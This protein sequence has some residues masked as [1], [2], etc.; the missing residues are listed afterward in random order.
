MTQDLLL[1]RRKPQ[2]GQIEHHRAE[3]HLFLRALGAAPSTT[4]N[5]QAM[6]I[7]SVRE[8]WT[9]SMPRRFKN[10]ARGLENLSDG[11]PERAFSTQTLCQLTGK[12][13]PVPSALENASFAAKR[14]ARYA[15]PLRWRRKR[16]SSE[17]TRILSA[18]RS[19]KRSRAR[20]IRPT[21]QRSV[22]IPRITISSSLGP[23]RLDG[24]PR[25]NGAPLRRDPA[26]ARRRSTRAR[27]TLPAPSAPSAG[28][29]ANSRD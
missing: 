28:R 19:P 18:K 26:P 15:A 20:S 17:A 24:S 12:R 8:T 3:R 2:P 10:A 9:L 23:H 16:S 1:L 5:A 7:S 21:S 27:W 13:M 6:P 25:D 4:T 29:P 11:F 22:P 14:L